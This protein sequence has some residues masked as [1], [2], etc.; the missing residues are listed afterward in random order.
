MRVRATRL[1]SISQGGGGLWTPAL[2]A[3]TL[4]LDA[5]DASTITLNG[6]TVSQWSDKSGTG[7]HMTNATA[8][9]QP[10]YSATGFNGMPALDFDATDDFLGNSSPSS[11]NSSLDFFYAAVFQMRT[12]AGTWRMVMGGRSTF[13]GP[14]TG[15]PCLQRMSD[16]SQIGIHN[17][18][19][20]DTRIK[21]DVTDITA[22]RIATVGRAG[23]TNGNGGA[24]TVTAT[25]PS[26]ATYLTAAT[27]TWPSSVNS[28]FQIGGRQQSETSWFN[29]LICEC[30]AMQ[31][32]ATTAERQQV[33]G[34]FAH[35]WGLAS[36]LP[37]DHPYRNTA[38]TV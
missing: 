3:P 9:S 10:L 13:N 25:G 23:G 38:P 4:W 5:A 19:Q 37:A 16:A 12:T 34:Y 6:S 32:N 33:E 1:L 18:D 11:L 31:R 22:P 8:S 17:T 28:V 21:V 36:S 30:V 7:N 26:Q 15:A 24:V 14:L 29:G 27:Q 35:K 20:Q 2:L